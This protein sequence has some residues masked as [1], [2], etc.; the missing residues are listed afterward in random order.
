MLVVQR[1]NPLQ[2]R[3]G[4]LVLGRLDGD[5]FFEK[6]CQRNVR[7]CNRIVDCVIVFLELR[8]HLADILFQDTAVGLRETAEG[9][10][11]GFL[12]GAAGNGSAVN[13]EDLL[14]LGDGI[15]Y[16]VC[17]NLHLV[18]A[19][20]RLDGVGFRLVVQGVDND[21]VCMRI[22]GVK[23]IV[24]CRRE[25]LV[26][27]LFFEKGFLRLETVFAEKGG[28]CRIGVDRLVLESQ[29]HAFLEEQLL[30]VEET[31]AETVA[32]EFPVAVACNRLFKK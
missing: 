15:G 14:S 21:L 8:A 20:E 28:E 25:H 23:E 17:G 31:E 27:I 13:H 10:L 18:G 11:P 24:V 12:E 1:R 7:R 4:I 29:G 16:D 22:R 30:R 2:D 9:W 5:E 19:G 3:S 32:R 6:V 26:K